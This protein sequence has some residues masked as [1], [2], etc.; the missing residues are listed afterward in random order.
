MEDDLKILKIEYLTNGL[1]DYTQILNLILHEQTVFCK[2][3]RW[4]RPPL[5]DDLKIIKMEYLSNRYSNFKLKLI[6]PN[7]IVQIL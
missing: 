2:S 7:Y 1:L 4:R 5:K 3:L 6:G